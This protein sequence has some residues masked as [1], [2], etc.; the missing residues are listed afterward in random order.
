MGPTLKSKIYCVRQAL[1]KWE[2]DKWHKLRGGLRPAESERLLAPFG[3]QGNGKKA[4]E[5]S[6]F[7]HDI[8][9]ADQSSSGIITLMGRIAQ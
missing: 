6:E 1:N 2:L 4:V 7:T 8:I 5:Q 3:R 9:N